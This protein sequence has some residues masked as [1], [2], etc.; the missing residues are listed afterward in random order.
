MANAMAPACVDC[1]MTFWSVCFKK[2]DNRML[3]AKCIVRSAQG[4]RLTRTPAHRRAP[5][6][7]AMATTTMTTMAMTT[8]MIISRHDDVDDHGRHGADIGADDDDHR[9]HT[10][11]SC[12]SRPKPNGPGL[13]LPVPCFCA[14]ARHA[15]F[16]SL[17]RG[18]ALIETL[19]HR[20][21]APKVTSTR[22]SAL[23][24]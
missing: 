18:F 11:A 15:T 24:H 4:L 5:L 13:R 19:P 1:L 17:V 3:V 2:N 6:P 23:G 16:S 8:M 10:R 22:M 20:L 21:R 14:H 12:E 9:R 7:I